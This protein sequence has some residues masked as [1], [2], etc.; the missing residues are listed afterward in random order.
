MQPYQR[1]SEETRK[2]AE[3]PIRALKTAGS[4]GLTAATAYAGGAAL[5]RVLP[6]LSKYIPED[7]AIKGLSKIDPRFGTFINKAMQAGKSFDEVRDFIGEKA[8]GENE[9][10]KGNAQEK[11]NIIQQYDPELHTYI[12]QVIKNG[13]TP[14]E[15]GLKAKG[16]E[17]FKKAIDKMVKDH[18]TTW[19]DIIESVFGGMGQTQPPALPQ[20]TQQIPQQPTQ[21]AQSG[22]G[23]QALMAIL[24]KIQQSR[25]MQ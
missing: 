6:M 7:L 1:A 4:I 16:H 13:K 22:Q 24:Q 25:G 23:Q 2:Q 8:M 18:K 5:N 9:E 14:V 3:M 15:A 11:R 20:Q 21:K 10:S 12:E 19:T 17:R